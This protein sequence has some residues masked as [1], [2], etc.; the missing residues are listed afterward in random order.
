M[1]NAINHTQ[2]LNLFSIA[3]ADNN[4]T[5]DELDM[6]NDFAVKRGI[7]QSEIDSILENPHKVKFGIPESTEEKIGNLYELAKMIQSDN[8][9]DIREIQVFRSIAREM[10]FDSGRSQTIVSVL[11]EGIESGEVKKSLLRK[12]SEFLNDK[13]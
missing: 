3:I 1:K 7:P 10:G 6:L 9:I 5:S 4:V 2:L 13:Y 8:K 12:V 11:L